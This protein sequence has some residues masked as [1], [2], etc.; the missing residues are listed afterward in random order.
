M[1]VNQCI[2]DTLRY[3]M[4]AWILFH[5]PRLNKRS[6]FVQMVLSLKDRL[7]NKY[8]LEKKPPLYSHWLSHF[9]KKRIQ[10]RHRG[11]QVD[12]HYWTLICKLN[13]R[14]QNTSNKKSW[15]RKGNHKAMGN[16]SGTQEEPGTD[17]GWK[18][19]NRWRVKSHIWWTDETLLYTEK[20]SGKQTKTG[21]G[22]IFNCTPHV[23]IKQNKWVNIHKNVEERTEK[24][25]IFSLTGVNTSLTV[26]VI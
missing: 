3:L 23:L 2:W 21:S 4:L 16:K 9:I 25:G 7:E 24:N 26:I 10:T 6:E 12:P 8:I 14:I 20:G 22:T 13:N 19:R 5:P 11:R 1:N 18:Q 17:P 15:W